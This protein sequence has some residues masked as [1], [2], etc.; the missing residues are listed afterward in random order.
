MAAYLG[1]DPVCELP[2]KGYAQL[3][4]FRENSAHEGL[5]CDT[6]LWRWSRHPNYVFEWLC[7]LADPVI[8]LSPDDALSSATL[9][10]PAFIDW[11]L[12]HPPREEKML[13][14]IT[15]I[16]RVPVRSSREEST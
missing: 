5:V 1:A 12:L 4:S 8:A 14:S 11:I 6:G 10:T 7:W 15:R 13:R 2:A 3:K 9:L 16:S